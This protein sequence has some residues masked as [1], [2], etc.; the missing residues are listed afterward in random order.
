MNTEYPV[1]APLAKDYAA[2][3][4]LDGFY[5]DAILERLTD[6]STDSMLAQLGI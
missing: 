2:I 1:I 5:W 3:W 6:Y 4:H